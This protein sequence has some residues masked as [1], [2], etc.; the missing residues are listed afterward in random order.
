MASVFGM[1]LV[2]SNCTIAPF[3]A[4]SG[5]MISIS[6]LGISPLMARFLAASSSLTAS[7][8]ALFH[9]AATAL[10][11]NNSVVA[12]AASIAPKKSLRFELIDCINLIFLLLAFDF[13]AGALALLSAPPQ[14]IAR[15]NCHL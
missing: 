11:G 15:K 13:L 7:N 9:S 12:V 4:R 1:R 14:S 10:R 3:S 8:A 6:L 2:T 5:A